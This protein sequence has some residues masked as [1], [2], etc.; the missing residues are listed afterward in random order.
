MVAGMAAA[1]RR[2]FLVDI[3]D[4]WLMCDHQDARE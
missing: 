1:V 4:E 3:E 2:V